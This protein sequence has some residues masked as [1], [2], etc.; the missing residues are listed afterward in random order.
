MKAPHKQQ[1]VSFSEVEV[2]LER[3][4]G[5][6]PV[7]SPQARKRVWHKTQSA[8]ASPAAH[9]VFHLSRAILYPVFTLLLAIGFL[10]GY[11]GVVLASGASVPGEPLYLIERKAET[12]WLSLTP[13]SRRC[14]VELVLLE[15][16]VYEAKALL[17]AGKPVP[18]GVLQEME[19]LFLGVV[20]SADCHEV[21]ASVILSH[22]LVY[23][24]KIHALVLQHPAI[25][26]LE[27]V[28]EA[29]NTAIIAFGGEPLEALPHKRLFG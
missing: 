1:D 17:D 26:E 28:L 24:Q 21:Q 5:S 19:M 11:G 7:L 18:P 10:G 25:W 14:E 27:A 8:L 3:L 15:R 16:R 9:R 13:S 2:T 22:L 20:D 4:L 6:A 29:A 23:R 12:V